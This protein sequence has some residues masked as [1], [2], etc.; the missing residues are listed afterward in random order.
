MCV[1]I[2]GLLCSMFFLFLCAG[3]PPCCSSSSCYCSSGSFFV[4]VCL[5]CLPRLGFACLALPGGLP[6]SFGRQEHFLL[7]IDP[8]DLSSQL[9]RA[10]RLGQALV[11]CG[12]KFF[13]F[14][15]SGFGTFSRFV[16]IKRNI[17]SILKSSGVLFGTFLAFVCG[18]MRSS[19]M[20][21]YWLWYVSRPIL[22][23]T[24]ERM[25]A[26]AQGFLLPFCYFVFVA[27]VFFGFLLPCLAVK[28]N[29]VK[30]QKA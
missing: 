1:I 25:I 20:F 15:Y 23:C 6:T 3:L 10:L 5:P 4:F 28:E 11:A 19:R 17:W 22:P 12:D 29:K 16:K 8:N 14:L 9:M 30:S 24:R 7:L 18:C 21:F 2:V 26:F 13:F 27:V